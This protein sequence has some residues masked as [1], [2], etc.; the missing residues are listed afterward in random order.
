MRLLRTVGAALACGLSVVSSSIVLA[1][2]AAASVMRFLPIEELARSSTQ[3]VRARITGQSVHWTA[4]HEG[5]YTEIEAVATG[6][7]KVA[8]GRPGTPANPGRR[9]TIIQAGGEIDGVSLDWTGRPTF[10][11]GEE[12][13]LFLQP[14]DENDLSDPRLLVVGGKQGRMRV[15]EDPRGGAPVMVERDL[16]GVL[17]APFIEGDVPAGP[18][19]RR[20]LVSLDELRQ[21]VLSAGGAR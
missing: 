12:L 19:P 2:P 7:I 11:T 3:V 13:I 14:Y 16:Q 5:I 10:R 6:D 17:D 21:R 1:P 8:P 18:A 20:D 9:M 15:L 4:N